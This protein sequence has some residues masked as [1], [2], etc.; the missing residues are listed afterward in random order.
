MLNFIRFFVLHIKNIKNYGQKFVKPIIYKI[1]FQRTIT[2]LHFFNQ[3]STCKSEWK[4]D[5]IIIL[6]T[7]EIKNIKLEYPGYWVGILTSRCLP[8]H[9]KARKVLYI[10]TKNSSLIFTLYGKDQR[11]IQRIWFYC[12]MFR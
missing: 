4:Y 12:K 11:I 7:R 8:Y 3:Q 10:L 2:K 9:P 6:F 5:S 1:Y